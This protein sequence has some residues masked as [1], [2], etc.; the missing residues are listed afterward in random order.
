M[1]KRKNIPTPSPL[2]HLRSLLADF[3][4]SQDVV[5]HALSKRGKTIT[6]W[7]DWCFL[8]MAAAAAFVQHH[9]LAPQCIAT[10]AA[11]WT[12]NQTRG[13][14]R[15]DEAL[16]EAL[17][18]MDPD[19]ALPTEVFEN[20]PE[21]CPYIETP[22]I[23]ESRGFWVHL[24]YDVN[25]G[26]RELRFLLDTPVGEKYTGPLPALILHL[27]KGGTIS[28][29]V[30][31]ATEEKIRQTARRGFGN[32]DNP[33]IKEATMLIQQVVAEPH[34]VREI[35]KRIPLVLYLCAEN[36]DLC[37]IG[38]V[39][40]RRP[41]DGKRGRKRRRRRHHRRPASKPSNARQWAVGYRIGAK[42]RKVAGERDH[43]GWTGTGSPKRP[44]IR[45]AHWH[46]FWRGPRHGP[47]EIVI[48]WLPPIPINCDFAD[49]DLPGV[50][51]PVGGCGSK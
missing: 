40:S 42:L 45:R 23:D 29:G 5:A 51:R 6:D 4:E 1:T 2:R 21:W 26:R 9:D 38:P 8:P 50:V 27:P 47:R 20:L 34:E 13:I 46:S 31:L 48:H 49:E 7:P 10:F 24:E 43:A 11:L 35:A 16:V 3:P 32:L 37:D 22:H 30:S 28:Q 25:T 17:E 39:Y 36:K 41:L 12:W 18:D 14:Y 44:H 15:F 33:A 19:K